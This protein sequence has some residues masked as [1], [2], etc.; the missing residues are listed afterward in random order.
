MPPAPIPIW[1]LAEVDRALAADP[2]DQAIVIWHAAAAATLGD[3]YRRAGQRDKG[4]R[5]T[6]AGIAELENLLA[7]KPPAPGDIYYPLAEGHHALAEDA[8]QQ[9]SL[10]G[11]LAEFAEEAVAIP[12]DLDVYRLRGENQMSAAAVEQRLSSVK[13]ADARRRLAREDADRVLGVHPDNPLAARLR[14][15]AEAALR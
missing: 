4:M 11:A 1:I 13:E 10:R 2:T 6:K 12:D 5:L 9:G 15:A 14:L 7:K 8:L 3:V